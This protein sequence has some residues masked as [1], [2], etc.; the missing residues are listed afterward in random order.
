MYLIFIHNQAVEMHVSFA[1]LY[2][3]SMRKLR[4]NLTMET[5]L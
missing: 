2:P 1:F 3:L 5:D 4:A